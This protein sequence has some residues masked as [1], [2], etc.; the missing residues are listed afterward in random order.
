MDHFSGALQALDDRNRLKC[1]SRAAVSQTAPASLA[2]LRGR[3]ADPILSLSVSYLL[4]RLVTQAA[5]SCR[6]P[7]LGALTT[8]E[9]V[10][11][12]SSRR[13]RAGGR[14]ADNAKAPAPAP[15]LLKRLHARNRRRQ[16]PD[17]GL[18]RIV[19]ERIAS[20]FPNS[21]GATRP[22]ATHMPVGRGRVV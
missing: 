11:A 3:Y 22:F 8:L 21:S 9:T 5:E 16:V 2:S 7:Q 12:A 19:P 13:H 17:H 10:T 20:D 1:V 4:A 6:R 14:L 18:H 15:P